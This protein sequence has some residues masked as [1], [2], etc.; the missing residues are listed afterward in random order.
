MKNTKKLIRELLILVN[1][2]NGRIP[3]DIKTLNE[4]AQK[5]IKA[6]EWSMDEIKEALES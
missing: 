4:K 3:E 2:T 1:R 6:M 5:E